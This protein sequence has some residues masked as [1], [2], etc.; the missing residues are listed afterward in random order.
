M[1]SSLKNSPV[2][3]VWQTLSWF[4]NHFH[5]WV[6]KGLTPDPAKEQLQSMILL[7]PQYTL[8]IRKHKC[9]LWNVMHY[10]VKLKFKFEW[11]KKTLRMHTHRLY[12]NCNTWDQSVP[13]PHVMMMIIHVNMPNSVSQWQII[14][15]YLLCD[16]TYLLEHAVRL[17]VLCGTF[18][19]LFVFLMRFRWNWE[20]SGRSTVDSDTILIKLTSSASQQSSPEGSSPVL[21]RLITPAQQ[22]SVGKCISLFVCH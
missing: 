19:R 3:L 17:H 5:N 13:F 4:S 10:R 12:Y 7:L 16:S 1:W 20:A 21:C 15:M 6:N 8:F 22:L 11:K 18:R 14:L 2:T 9:M